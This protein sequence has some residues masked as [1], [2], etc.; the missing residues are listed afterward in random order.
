MKLSDLYSV[1]QKIQISLMK[2][3][4]QQT[5]LMKRYHIILLNS[6][7]DS[8]LSFWLPDEAFRPWWNDAR[9]EH[10]TSSRRRCAQ[11]PRKVYLMPIKC[12]WIELIGGR[13]RECVCERV[14]WELVQCGTKWWRKRQRLQTGIIISHPSRVI[15]CPL[16]SDREA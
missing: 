6:R 13:Q 4:N 10:C 3:P 16:V 8:A 14:C 2:E 11:S 15:I 5:R 1:E 7:R 9:S 12:L